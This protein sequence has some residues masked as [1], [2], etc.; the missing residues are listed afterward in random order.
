VEFA[1]AADPEWAKALL[2]DTGLLEFRAIPRRYA[3]G[4]D[5]GPEIPATGEGFPQT[6]RDETGTAVDV[7]D[8]VAESPVIVSGRDFAPTSRVETRADQYTCVTFSLRNAGR[9]A[10]HA[11]TRDNVDSYLAMVLDGELIACPI[12]R[13]AIPGG[14]GVIEGGFDEPGGKDRAEKLAILINSG[15][16]PLDLEFVESTTEQLSP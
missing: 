8:V 14:Q 5:R 11:F 4:E 13:S 9:E 15:P 6:F 3:H 16:L 1:C 12:I 7:S 2:T 10:F